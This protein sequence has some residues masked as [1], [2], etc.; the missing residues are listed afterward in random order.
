MALEELKLMEEQ[1]QQLDE[2]A[3]TCSSIIRTRYNE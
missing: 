1:I 2:E 3:S